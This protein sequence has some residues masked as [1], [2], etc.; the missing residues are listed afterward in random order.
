MLAKSLSGE[1]LARE[2][3][4]VLPVTYS[5]RSNTVLVAMRCGASVNSV[6]ICTLRVVYLL[7]IDVQCFS[8]T[9][10]HVGGH[11]QIQLKVNS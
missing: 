8:H 9:I 7:L 11:F 6:A 2:L 5:I 3:I 1:E 10:D 4:S